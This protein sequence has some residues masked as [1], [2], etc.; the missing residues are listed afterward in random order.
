MR[1]KVGLFLLSLFALFIAPISV[2]PANAL[3]GGFASAPRSIS[4]TAISGGVTLAWSVPADLGNG[5]LNYRVQKSS[6]GLDDGGWT[7]VATPSTSPYTVLGLTTSAIYLRV[8]AVTSAGTGAFGYPWTTVFKTTTKTR[9]SNSIIYDTDNSGTV[10]SSFTRVR[11]L[12]ENTISTASNYADVDFYKWAQGGTVATTISTSVTA[13]PTISNL[14]VPSPAVPFTVQANVSDLT[15]YSSVASTGYYSNAI[16]NGFGIN[17]R[18]ELWDSNYATTQ[19]GLSPPGDTSL[20]DYDDQ[21]AAGAYGSF[22]VHNLDLSKTIFA[23]NQHGVA[24][25]DIGFGDGT[26]IASHPDWT[27]CGGNNSLCPAVTTFGLTIFVNSPITPLSDTTPP[28]VSRI[29]NRFY[30]KN[31]DTITVRSTELGTVYLVSQA[32]TVTNLASISSAS[33]S[34]KISTS[35]SA[36]NTN[37]TMTIGYQSNGLYN[38]YAAD[39][40]GNLSTAILATIRIDNTSPTATSI[41]VGSSGTFLQLTANETITNSLQVFGM[42][43][44]TDSGSAISVNSIA[45]SGLTATLGLS[46]AIPAGAT[47]YFTYTPS[48]GNAGGRIVDLAGNEMAPITSRTVTNNSTSPISVTLTLPDPISKGVSI[49]ASVSVSVAG[50]VTFYMS[51]K[52]IA[53][54][55]NKVASG[56]TPITVTCTFKPAVT[57][58]Q[59]V[60]ATLTPTLSAYPLTTSSVERYI[61]KRTTTR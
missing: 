18:V 16:T 25:P 15:V 12:F 51:G 6:T 43:A 56:A 33:T 11:Y 28:T 41:A 49:T 27:F 9:S 42:F 55:L 36:A 35:I 38:L 61:L 57:A 39:L 5:V 50:K 22:Q 46:R 34:S 20:Y 21:P 30:A 14:Q 26:G 8:A 59:T 48:S 52:R 60:S 13:Q 32:V 37:T 45:V 31:A 40:L 53:G 10:S 1:I 54:C 23:W 4:Q 44:V 29:D 2:P 24:K 7:D 19:N 58:R 3:S 47:V 17:G